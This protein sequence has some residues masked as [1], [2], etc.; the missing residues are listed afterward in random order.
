MG[1]QDVLTLFDISPVYDTSALV[2]FLAQD[3]A[4]DDLCVRVRHNTRSRCSTSCLPAVPW[5]PIRL[6]CYVGHLMISWEPTSVKRPKAVALKEG[7]PVF[8]GRR[9]IIRVQ[10]NRNVCSRTNRPHDHTGV[11]GVWA[12]W[13]QWPY[14]GTGWDGG[15]PEKKG[16]PFFSGCRKYSVYNTTETCVLARTVRSAAAVR[17]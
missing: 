6:K 14:W 15:S 5:R 2:V 3:A 7:H 4:R 10:H 13:A 11:S 16:N 17:K 1:V 8:L 12:V 9:I